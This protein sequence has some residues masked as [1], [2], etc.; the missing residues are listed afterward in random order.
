[1]QGWLQEATR[2][3]EPVRTRWELLVKILKRN[4]GGGTPLAELAWATMVLI[5]KGKWEYWGIGLVEVAW[6]LCAVVV[7]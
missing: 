7:N 1:M 4:F 6:K 3:R 5:P 2:K